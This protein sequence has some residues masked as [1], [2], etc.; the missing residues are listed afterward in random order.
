[1]HKYMELINELERSIEAGAYK[2]GVKLPSVRVMAE[3]YGCNAGTVVRAM[4]ELEKRHLIYSVPKSGYYVVVR[5]T[6]RELPKVQQLD[7]ATFSPDPDVFPYLDFRHCINKAID[8]YRNELFVYGTPKGLPSLIQVVRKQL[9]NYQVFAPDSRIC[10]T[11][12]VQQALALLASMPLPNGGTSLLVE[13]PGYHLVNEL[14]ETLQLPVIGI[15]RTAKGIDLDELERLFRTGS[16]K[17]FYTIPR[18]HSPLGS[19][20][21]ETEKKR[22]AELAARYGVYIVEDDYLADM[23]TNGKSDPIYAYDTAGKVIYLKSYSKLIFPGLRVGVA[24]LPEALAEPFAR[25][26]RLSDIDSSMLSQ[27]ALEIYLKSGMYERHKQKLRASWSRRS[28]LLAEVLSRYAG[29]GGEH[30]RFEAASSPSTHTHIL[31][32]D[33]ASI[34]G[35]IA[36]LSKRS[37]LVEPVDKHYLSGFPKE[38]IVKLTVSNVKEADIERGVAMIAEELGKRG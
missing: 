2:E 25:R 8:T 7:F 29:P 31:P 13:Q 36:R 24:V 11:S 32:N 22:I 34:P 10:I 17:L 16:I 28:R 12:G 20:Y 33:K 27:A 35:L 5:G 4:G 26:K 38:R 6:Q 37:V 19:S 1:M 3:R 23:E 30:Y 18:F 14:V 9:T 15:R 21:T